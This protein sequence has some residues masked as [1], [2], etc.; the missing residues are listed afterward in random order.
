[1][2]RAQPEGPPSPARRSSIVLSVLFL[3]LLLAGLASAP[4]HGSIPRDRPPAVVSLALIEGTPAAERVAGAFPPARLELE[5]S[6]G[7]AGVLRRVL[8]RQN[9]WSAFDPEGLSLWSDAREYLGSGLIGFGEVL[10]GNY[11][12]PTVSRMDAYGRQ[13]GRN[14][15]TGIGLLL[16]VDGLP[17]IGT[18]VGMMAAAGAGEAVT[19]GGATPVALPVGAGGFVI[20]TAGAVETGTGLLMLSHASGLPPI[21]QPTGNSSGGGSSPEGSAR[22]EKK[23]ID[24]DRP[25]HGTK[26]H[27]AT[28]FNEAKRMENDPNVT[29]SRFN[30]QLTDVNGNK[31]SNLKPDAQSTRMTR[32]GKLVKDVTEVRSPSQ[33]E[34]FMN[35]KVQKLRDQLGD[36]AGDVKWIEPRDAA[37]R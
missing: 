4:L 15:A 18:G 10:T 22:P 31:A 35:E 19:A 36:Q 32:D 8:V 30:Q 9:P 11:A 27:D 21:S 29:D 28:A 26:E 33:S 2:K 20:A 34:K 14:L 1:M 16:T 24:S 17:K 23:A 25:Q 13:G 37:R 5:I 12:G 3:W 6:E 7:D